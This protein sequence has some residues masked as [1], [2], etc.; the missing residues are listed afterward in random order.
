MKELCCLL[1]SGKWAATSRELRQAGFYAMTRHRA[2]GR[3]RQ[4]GLHGGGDG[5]VRLLPK[6]LLLMVVEEARVPAAVEAIVRSNRT[7]NVGDGKIFITSVLGTVRVS[8]DEFGCTA[9]S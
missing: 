3:G 4:K 7:G 6:W 1:R 2:M 5:G 8:N 9:L